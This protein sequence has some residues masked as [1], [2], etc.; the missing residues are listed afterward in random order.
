MNATEARKRAMEILKVETQKI[1]K[2]VEEDIEKEI[3]KGHFSLN[4][5]KPITQDVKD[6]LKL[7]GFKI[8]YKDCYPND[9]YNQ[10]SW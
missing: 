9:Y 5:Y 6:L 7:R 4:Y 1:I 2:D 3:Q 8:E 10:I